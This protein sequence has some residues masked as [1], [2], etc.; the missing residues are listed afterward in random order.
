M[1]TWVASAN[2]GQAVSNITGIPTAAGNFSDQIIFV[3]WAANSDV[4]SSS[5]TA[6]HIIMP[7]D[8]TE[9][10]HPETAVMGGLDAWGTP[11]TPASVADDYGVCSVAGSNSCSKLSDFTDNSKVITILPVLSYHVVFVA[12]KTNDDTSGFNSSGTIY[13]W[14][15]GNDIEASNR[16]LIGDSNNWHAID[17]TDKGSLDYHVFP[18]ALAMGPNDANNASYNSNLFVGYSNGQ[19]TYFE[20]AATAPIYQDNESDPFNETKIISCDYWSN[21]GT[22]PTEN[23]HW[24]MALDF[25]HSKPNAD[26]SKSFSA[27]VEQEFATYSGHSGLNVATSITHLDD[28][29]YTPNNSQWDKT[30]I[31]D[32]NNDIETINNG[33]SPKLATFISAQGDTYIALMN[34]QAS[35][36]FA[37]KWQGYPYGMVKTSGSLN[38]SELG[39]GMLVNPSTNKCTYPNEITSGIFG[40]N[41]DD[42]LMNDNSHNQFDSFW[43]DEDSNGAVNL[44][45]HSKSPVALGGLSETSYEITPTTITVPVDGSKSATYYGVPPM[46]TG[47]ANYH[48]KDRPTYERDGICNNL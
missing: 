46:W 29:L 22:C 2:T 32:F 24:I 16:K 3:K 30:S 13:R 37:Y 39:R 4:S 21:N 15:F 18:T 44:Y 33:I 9:I 19:V 31:T 1:P 8:P 5:T 38:D 42:T 20:H 34:N 12:I 28:I 25:S 48:K 17:D 35:E 43:F 47:Y 11:S 26:S 45:A 41:A 6:F 27:V 10:L 36:V 7:I 14:T 23:D 40:S